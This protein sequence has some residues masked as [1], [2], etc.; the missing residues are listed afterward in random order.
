MGGQHGPDAGKQGVADFGGHPGVEAVGDD[1]VELPGFRGEIAEVT[2]FEADVFQ[3]GFADQTAAAAGGGG[4]DIHAV[5]S[6]A[7]ED[8]GRGDEVEA[9]AAADFEDTGGLNRGR[10]Q[11]EQAGH[12]GEAVG[13]AL[14]EGF[15]GVVDEVVVSHSEDFG[16]MLRAEAVCADFLLLSS[17]F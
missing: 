5:E 2:G 7:G 8:D 10:L 15:G 12:E 1:V 17:S 14:G 11:T 3:A 4:A 6:R 9:V 13:V 16:S